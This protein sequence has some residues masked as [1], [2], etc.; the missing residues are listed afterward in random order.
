MQFLI[1]FKITFLLALGVGFVVTGLVRRLA[2]RLRIVDAPNLP[3]KIHGTP[4]PLLGGLALFGSVALCVIILYGLGWLL[5]GRVAPSLLFGVMLAAS[6]L[7]LVGSLDDKFRLPWWQQVIGPLAAVTIVFWYGLEIPYV[8][9]PLGPGLLH[10][11]DLSLS[12]GAATIVVPVAAIALYLW[13]LGMIYTTKLLDG[14][15]GLAASVSFVA[16]LVI[17]VVSLSWDRTGSA[18]SFLALILA[19]CTAGFLF[20]NFYP[21]KIFLGEGGST[22][23]GFMLAVLAII[24]GGKIATALLVMGVPILDVLWIIVRRLRTGQKLY[25]GDD[26]HLHFRLLRAGMSQRQVVLFVAGISLLFGSVSFFFTTKG[27]LIA[28]SVLVLFMVLLAIGLIRYY[29]KPVSHR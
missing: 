25:V 13:I 23:L 14:I 3:R 10:L 21:A 28:L 29:E 20:W 1:P 4:L 16:S 12:L 6:V 27:K 19:G 22:F 15:D 9:N 17:F 8:T 24:S 5:D 2:M 18:T 11:T 26:K 7:V